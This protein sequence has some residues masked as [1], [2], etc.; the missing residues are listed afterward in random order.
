MSKYTELKGNRHTLL[1]SAV[2]GHFKRGGVVDR[3][4]RTLPLYTGPRSPVGNV[5]GYICLTADPGVGTLIP[6]RGDLS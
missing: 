2:K 5:S 3:G 4:H 6:A 1:S